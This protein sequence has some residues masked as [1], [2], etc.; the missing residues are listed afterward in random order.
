MAVFLRRSSTPLLPQHFVA[1][2]LLTMLGAIPPKEGTR[3]VGYPVV[4]V[5]AEASLARDSVS[6]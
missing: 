6:L 1:K 2:W 4:V 3:R 5:D